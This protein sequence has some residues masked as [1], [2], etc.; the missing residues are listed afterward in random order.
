MY[1]TFAFLP[2]VGALNRIDT[3][4]ELPALASTFLFVG[5]QLDP[6]YG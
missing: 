6:E 2:V 4:I 5:W 1:M 3:V